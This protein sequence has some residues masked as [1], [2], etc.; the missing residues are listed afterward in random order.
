MMIQV[1][2]KHP[3]P[4]HYIF[5]DFWSDNKALAEDPDEI[6]VVSLSKVFKSKTTHSQ[7]LILPEI[8]EPEVDNALAQPSLPPPDNAQAQ[9]DRAEETA[10]VLIASVRGKK[11]PTKGK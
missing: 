5:K 3:I 6:E 7:A 8:L 2:L 4:G 1:G 10:S 9:L 11:P